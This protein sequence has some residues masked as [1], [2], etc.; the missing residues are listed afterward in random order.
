MP[1]GH[2]VQLRL[3]ALTVSAEARRPP[4]ERYHGSIGGVSCNRLLCRALFEDR[5][6]AMVLRRKR[7]V[8]VLVT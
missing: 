5:A 7:T 1:N 3:T 6:C 2:A 4:P 8:Q